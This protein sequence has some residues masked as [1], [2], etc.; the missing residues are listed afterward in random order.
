MKLAR[1]N[2]ALLI[3]ILVVNGYIVIMP[4]LPRLIY[5]WQDLGSHGRRAELQRHITPII[6]HDPFPSDNRIVIPN[7]H[8]DQPIIEGTNESALLK[9]PWRLPQ[10]SMP[11]KGGNTVIAGHRFT[12]TNPRGTFYFLDRLHNG[13]D[14]AVYWHGKEYL[15]QVTTNEVVP[16]TQTSIE[17]PTDKPRLTLFSC[18][19]LWWPKN[20][21]VV[22]ANLEKI[23]E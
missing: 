2:T 17:N 10:T 13:D 6:G 16:P 18:T 8:L 9:G 1:V 4:I 5:H 3:L 14:I 22:V 23:Y 21:L 12:Y 15:Y 20:R 11:D 19:P 7:M